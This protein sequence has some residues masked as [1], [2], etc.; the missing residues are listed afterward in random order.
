MVIWV[1]H[2]W[3]VCIFTI[4]CATHLPSTIVSVCVSV[5]VCMCVCVR[6][7][8]VCVRVWA[9]VCV[10]ARAIMLFMNSEKIRKSVLSKPHWFIGCKYDTRDN[11]VQIS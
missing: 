4:K 10:R 1:P 3:N 11:V 6:A 8:C 9:C 5:F 7:L 2:C